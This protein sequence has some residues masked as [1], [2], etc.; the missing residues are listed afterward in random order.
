MVGLN[1]A[2]EQ[3]ETR[4]HR[5]VHLACHHDRGL[6][7]LYPR[8]CRGPGDFIWQTSLGLPSFDLLGF[9]RWPLLF[10]GSVAMLGVLY[11]FDPITGGPQGGA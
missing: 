7:R 2:C 5:D 1:I 3:K 4:P 6:G 10:V 8:F 9:F 11:R